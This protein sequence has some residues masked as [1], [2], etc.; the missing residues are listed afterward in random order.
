MEY[1]LINKKI[2]LYGLGI[3]LILISSCQN[4]KG[5]VLG[6]GSFEATEILV[7]SE[8][9]GKVL[10]WNLEEGSTLK[11]G[12]YVGVIDT[13]QLYLQKEVLARSGKGVSAVRPDVRR[14]TAV[15]E[16]Q[17]NDLRNQ[18]SRV[19]KLLAAGAATQKELDDVE[20]GIASIQSQMEAARSTLNKSGAQIS[21]QSSSIDVQIAQI[22]D[23][24][25]RSIIKSPI[26]GTI[27][28][29][30]VRAGELTG[31]GRPLF[32]IADLNHIFLRAYIP[33]KKLA[34]INLGDSV[35]VR[36]DGVEGKA[37]EYTGKV[38]WIS[39]K[40]EF[41]PK[42]VQTEDE[43][44]NLVYA[45]KVLVENDGYIKIGMYGELV[46]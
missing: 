18:K 43:R 11:E 9:S 10:E 26:E 12:E 4:G 1:R 25:K 15:L 13:T 42:T 14:Q 46:E 20:T 45:V 27:L 38:T 32:R 35:K 22:E 6:S 16:V 19:E 23:L 39:S 8:V 36:V 34:H 21:A 5:D 41:T 30:Y 2:Y 37:K 3:L 31:S 44:A 28:A 24:I 33:T 7:S 40:S 29:N 17:L